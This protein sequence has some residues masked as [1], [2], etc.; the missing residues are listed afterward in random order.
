M[1]SYNV[2]DLV[3]KTLREHPLPANVGDLSDKD[4]D[5]LTRAA[6][7]Q[8]ITPEALLSVLRAQRE[9]DADTDSATADVVA[10]ARRT[11]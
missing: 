2:A 9:K 8:G 7:R 10:Y 4:R 11:V 6:A 3:T 1:S 5:A